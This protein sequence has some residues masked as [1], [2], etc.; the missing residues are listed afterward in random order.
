MTENKILFSQNI[1]ICLEGVVDDFKNFCGIIINNETSFKN[2]NKNFDKI[3]VYMYGDIKKTCQELSTTFLNL[4]IIQ[5][6]SFNYEDMTGKLISCGE[7][8]INVNNVGIFFPNFFNDGEEYFRLISSEHVFQELTESDKKSMA[9]RTGLYLTDVKKLKDNE[10][11]FNLL[12]CSSNFKGPTENFKNTDKKVINKVNNI[13][14]YLFEEYC[15][16]NHVLAQIYENKLINNSEKKASIREHS[17]KTK[18]MCANGV[19]AFCTF[20]ENLSMINIKKQKYDYL[21]KKTSVLTRLCFRL[22]SCVK[23]TAGLVKKFFVTLYPNSVFLMPLSTNRLYTHEIVPSTLSINMIPK[24]MGY[25]IRCS[26]TQAIFNTEDPVGTY[27][28]NH[29]NELVPLEEPTE[30]GIKLLKELYLKENVSDEIVKYDD[31]F[32][33]LNEGDYREPII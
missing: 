30:S 13:S 5:E 19:M 7:V 14:Q 11:S 24:R 25:V 18:D 15:P 16:V 31:I 26:K 3:I 28:Y 29:R 8:P 2:L 33:S 32:F 21:Y 23:E 20:Y 27:I 4:Y 22:K 12:R 1:L 9:F 17:D 6:M 10:L